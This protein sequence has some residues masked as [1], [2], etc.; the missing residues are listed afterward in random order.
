MLAVRD[1]KRVEKKLQHSRDTSLALDSTRV[2]QMLE[3]DDDNM[4]LSLDIEELT[5]RSDIERMYRHEVWQL[6]RGPATDD[7]RCDTS[8]LS[9]TL[10]FLSPVYLCF[11][12]RKMEDSL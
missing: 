2:S 8:I 10:F 1:S 7:R 3:D 5:L 9:S 4:S 11:F 6:M 12:F